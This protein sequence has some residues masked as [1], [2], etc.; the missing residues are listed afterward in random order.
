MKNNWS[1]EKL[2][3]YV[4]VPMQMFFVLVSS[5]IYYASKQTPIQF[6]F[7][8]ILILQTSIQPIVVCINLVLN[9][10]TILWY[11]KTIFPLT[12]L[13]FFISIWF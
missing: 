7:Y 13:M 6:L 11:T 8:V 3:L 5:T 2:L 10:K 12:W 9:S 4:L 1:F